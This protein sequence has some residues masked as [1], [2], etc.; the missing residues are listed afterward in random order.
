MFGFI[1]FFFVFIVT[2]VVLLCLSAIKKKKKVKHAISAGR[3]LE[4]TGL[5]SEIASMHLDV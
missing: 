4:R 3:A 2:E 5:V 1:Q